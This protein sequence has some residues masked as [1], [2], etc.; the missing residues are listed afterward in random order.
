MFYLEDMQIRKKL[1]Y[2]PYYD[3]CLIKLYS[4]DH[5]LLLNESNK[6]K[7]YLDKNCKNITILGPSPGILPKVYNKYNMQIILKYKKLN[8]V[9][10][11]LKFIKQMLNKNNKISIDI[12]FNPKKI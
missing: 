7:D 3:L 1:N 9:Y 6:L 4:I 12:D 11:Q 5:D 2:P 10:N 8:Q